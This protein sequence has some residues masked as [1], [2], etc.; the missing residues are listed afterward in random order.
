MLMTL[1]TALLVAL[2]VRLGYWQLERAAEKEAILALHEQRA[3]EAS[4]RLEG[5]MNELDAVVHRR[6][7][8]EGI[9]DVQHQVLLDNQVLNR[10]A[11]Y[12]VLTPLILEDGMAVLVNRGWL[13]VG[14]SRRQLPELPLPASKMKLIGR[15]SAP[16]G[17]IFKLSAGEA[18]TAGWPKVA[19]HVRPDEL[20][21]QLHYPLLPYIVLLDADQEYGFVRDW[22]VVAVHPGKH[23]SYA[24]QWFG[25]AA[26]LLLLYVL[27]NTRKVS[28][29]DTKGVPEE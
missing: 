27:L 7:I 17:T 8:V 9:Y 23:S 3:T 24:M 20:A 11:G 6:L 12:H 19:Q 18:Y 1:L 14:P 21:V 4:L 10:V 13:P 5:S 25:L 2:F 15:A 26:L 16:P 22:K 28:M 29:N